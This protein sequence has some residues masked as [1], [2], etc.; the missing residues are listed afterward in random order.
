MLPVDGHST[1]PR[2]VTT[3]PNQTRIY[4]TTWYDVTRHVPFR[5]PGTMYTIYVPMALLNY[6]VAHR[7]VNNKIQSIGGP[8]IYIFGQIIILRPVVLL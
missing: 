5:Y 6:R 4:H 8:G 3:T 1:L 2:K 7:D